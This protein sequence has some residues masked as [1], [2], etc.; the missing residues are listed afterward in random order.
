MAEEL[1]TN[2]IKDW[3]SIVTLIVFCLTSK[4]AP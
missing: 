3:R 2:Q 4:P 1:D